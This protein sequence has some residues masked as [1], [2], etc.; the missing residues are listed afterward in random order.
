MNI[1]S[2]MTRGVVRVVSDS[3]RAT[4]GNGREAEFMRSFPLPMRAPALPRAR[5][6]GS[7]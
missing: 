4:A 2:Y 3:L 1:Q 7:I 6:N 5:R